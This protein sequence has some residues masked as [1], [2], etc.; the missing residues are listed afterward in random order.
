MKL[1]AFFRWLNPKHLL[2]AVIPSLGL[3]LFGY[4][5]FFQ[6]P[7]LSRREFVLTLLLWFALTPLLYLLLTR[8]LLP[9]LNAYTPRARSNWLLLSIGVGIL[10]ALVFRL[11]RLILLLPNHALQTLVPAGAE[12]RSITLEIRPHPVDDVLIVANDFVL[13]LDD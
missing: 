11:S 10:F 9:R 12:G 7:L 6:S 2:L 4:L 8:F 5:I 1:S 13:N 3:S